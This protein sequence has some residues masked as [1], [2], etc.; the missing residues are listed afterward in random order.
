MVGPLLIG[1]KI[2]L[3]RPCQKHHPKH[4]EY[5]HFFADKVLPQSTSDSRENSVPKLTVSPTDP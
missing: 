1:R 2:A 5:R 3:A 4:C